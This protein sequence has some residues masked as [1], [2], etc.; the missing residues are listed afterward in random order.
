MLLKISE[1]MERRYLIHVG[2]NVDAAT[3]ERVER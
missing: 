1:L 2:W 3:A